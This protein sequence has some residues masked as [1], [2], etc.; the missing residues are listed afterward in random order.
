VAAELAGTVALSKHS[1]GPA[2]TGASWHQMYGGAKLLT[3]W[4]EI[5]GPM[6]KTRGQHTQRSS[7]WTFWRTFYRRMVSFGRPL[8]DTRELSAVLLAK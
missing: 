2:L 1:Q 3:V 8:T 5:K 6:G 7:R 4:G